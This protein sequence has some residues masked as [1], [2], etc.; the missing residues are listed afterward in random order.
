VK[1]PERSNKNKPKRKIMSGYLQEADGW[2]DA[3]FKDHADGKL[4]YAGLKHDIKDRILQSYKNGLKA[5]GQSP[6]PRERERQPRR[7]AERAK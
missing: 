3:L 5:A 6:A 2:L 1:R 4:S 7:F